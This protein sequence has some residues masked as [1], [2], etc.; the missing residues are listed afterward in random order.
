MSARFP[1]DR[2]G[3]RR[4]LRLPQPLLAAGAVAGLAR[5]FAVGAAEISMI[6]TASAARHRIDCAVHRRL[7]D[8]L[9]SKRVITAA[10]L[11]VVVPMAGAA[12]AR[13]RAGADRL[14]L[15]PRPAAAADLR[16]H[17]RLYRRRVAGGRHGGRRRHLHRRVERGR[18]LRPFHPGVLA[19][20]VGWR[21]AFLALA[22]LSLLGAGM[23]AVMLPRERGFVRST[24]LPPPAGRCSA[25]SPTRNCSPP[26]RSGSARC[27]ISSR[28]SP[29]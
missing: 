10:M 27:S 5:E 11:A 22:A 7:A 1:H 6:M 28:C 24:A 29:S 16:R 8:V 26:T 13:R 20:L 23:V 25:T 2:R 18:I 14:A 19:D 3:S 4:L 21:G 9:G 17:C 12:F 15:R